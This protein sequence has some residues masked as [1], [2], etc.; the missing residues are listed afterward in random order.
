[1]LGKVKRSKARRP[2]VSIVQTAGQA[3]MKLMSPKPHDAKRALVGLAPALE[4][5]VEL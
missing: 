1:M 5:I 4:K 3:K 2:N